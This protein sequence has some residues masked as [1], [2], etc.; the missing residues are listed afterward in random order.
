MSEAVAESKE[1]RR[2]DDITVRVWVIVLIRIGIRIIYR[3]RGR[4]W[5]YRGRY[6]GNWRRFYRLGR[7][8]CLRRRCGA[9]IENAVIFLTV[10]GLGS[11]VGPEVAAWRVATPDVGRH[12]IGKQK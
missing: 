8:T 3:R 9:R 1:E 2:R 11:L 10:A 4:R 6:L 12:W 7:W 5:R